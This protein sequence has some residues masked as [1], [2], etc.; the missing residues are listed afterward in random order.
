[1]TR[2][3]ND[4]H[5]LRIGNVH[6]PYTRTKYTAWTSDKARSLA[7]DS[8]IN[9]DLR[10]VLAGERPWS[11]NSVSGEK[12][13]RTLHDQ[14]LC[15]HPFGIFRCGLFEDVSIF[16]FAPALDEQACILGVSQ[17][18][19]NW[20]RLESSNRRIAAAFFV[21]EKERRQVVSIAWAGPLVRL[22]L[23]HLTG[24][25]AD[26]IEKAGFGSIDD[27]LDHAHRRFG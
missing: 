1:M 21:G 5:A 24:I 20:T 11:V 19:S 25:P 9:D 17:R 27:A 23:Y 3:D 7:M 6:V 2:N 18:W 13:Q 10:K 12:R 22:D 4:Y 8:V 16:G 26:R 15:L 14:L